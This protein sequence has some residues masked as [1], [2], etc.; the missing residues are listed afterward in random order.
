VFQQV[1]IATGKFIKN[2]NKSTKTIE[3]N[4]KY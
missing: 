2:Q 1:H 4:N 3:Q